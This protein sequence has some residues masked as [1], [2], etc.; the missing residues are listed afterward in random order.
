MGYVFGKL[1]VEKVKNKIFIEGNE[2]KGKK[3]IYNGDKMYMRLIC[4]VVSEKKVNES[5]LEI[6]IGF[7]KNKVIIVRLFMIYYL[8]LEIY[9]RLNIIV[10]WLDIVIYCFL[11][12]YY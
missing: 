2:N 5:F 3:V 4:D 8:F 7:K 6:F 1:V 9:D 11:I 10:Y 12:V